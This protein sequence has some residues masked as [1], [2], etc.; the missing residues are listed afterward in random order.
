MQDRRTHT[1]EV[2]SSRDFSR[3]SYSSSQLAT[4][5]RLPA[6]ALDRVVAGLGGIVLGVVSFLKEEITQSTSSKEN[7]EE[8]RTRGF[9]LPDQHKI[10]QISQSILF[11][12]L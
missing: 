6:E 9:L 1:S 5:F 2:I 3:V 11:S 12:Y 10:T 8:E 4:F 7:F